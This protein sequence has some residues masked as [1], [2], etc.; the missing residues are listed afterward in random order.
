MS[1][2]AVTQVMAYHDLDLGAKQYEVLK[3]VS[4]LET[5]RTPVSCENVCKYLGYTAN[6]VTGRLKELR[7]KGAITFDSFTKS[8]FGKNVETY[9]LV[10]TGQGSFL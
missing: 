4:H 10:T 3:A 1:N 9:K 7:D 2:Y 6:R 5:I 8:S